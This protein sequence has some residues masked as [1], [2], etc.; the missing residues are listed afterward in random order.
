MKRVYLRQVHLNPDKL[1]PVESKRNNQV[2]WTK[3]YSPKFMLEAL[4]LRIPS[5]EDKNFEDV[6]KLK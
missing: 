2:L 1:V 5:T 3:L 4:T 6:I